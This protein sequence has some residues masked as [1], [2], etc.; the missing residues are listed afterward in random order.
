M[1]DIGS[2]GF[3]TVQLEENNLT[4]AMVNKMA[5]IIYNPERCKEIG[6]FNFNIGKKYFSY[7]ILEEKLTKL[8]NF[9]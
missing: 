2:K 6:E 4:D 9:H 7:A 3:E 8:F 1:Q 5:D